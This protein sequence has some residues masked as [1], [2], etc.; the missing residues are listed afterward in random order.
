MARV[1]WLTMTS[2]SR[3]ELELEVAAAP[4]EVG[5]RLRLGALLLEE[6][7]V[8]DAASHLQLAARLDP[9]NP[10]LALMALDALVRA[11]R[12][13]DGALL[14]S[15]HVKVQ[16][17]ET[18]VAEQELELLEELL[19][20]PQSFVRCHTARAVGRLRI[21]Q[22]LEALEQTCQDSDGAVRLAAMTSLRQLQAH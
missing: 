9:R 20:H 4:G 16:P 12:A 3:E 21:V 22:C 18:R 17:V 8:E 19:C 11:D 13:K 14:L 5:P 10:H 1:L 6:G 7:E 2:T 15:S